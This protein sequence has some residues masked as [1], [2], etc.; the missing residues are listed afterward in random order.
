LGRADDRV[1]DAGGLDQILLGDLRPKVPVI[2]RTI[3]AYDRECDV[4]FAGLVLAFLAGLFLARRMVVPIQ[5]LRAGVAPS[6]C[7]RN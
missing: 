2:R 7:W 4:K 3:V 1:G 5:M 6:A